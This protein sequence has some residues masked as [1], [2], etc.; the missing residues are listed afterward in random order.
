MKN[1]NSKYWKEKLG[2][3]PHPEGGY[4]KEIYRSEEK[5]QTSWGK[6]R[7]V[8]TAIYYLLEEN[9]KSKFHRIKSDEIWHYYDGNT[10]VIIH[11]I[12][13]EGNYKSI[14]IGK[15]KDEALVGIVPKNTWFAAE[16]STK[17]ES[18]CLCGCTVSPGFDFEDFE[19]ANTEKLM[20][21]YPHLTDKIKDFLR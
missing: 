6:N 18:Y 15:G 14:K 1:K 3:F 7:N 5:T 21:E 17:Q 10:S 2:L 20:E 8:S 19:M 16:L 9:N 4:Y 11:C 12:D 13:N